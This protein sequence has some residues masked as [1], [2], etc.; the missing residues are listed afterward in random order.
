MVYPPTGSTAYERETSIPPTLLRSM[1]LLY[2]FTFNISSVQWQTG[3]EHTFSR[4]SH[5]FT[6]FLPDAVAQILATPLKGV[7]SAWRGSRT[8]LVGGLGTEV[9][10]RSRGRLSRGLGCLDD[11]MNL[12]NVS[13]TNSFIFMRSLVAASLL[14]FC[15]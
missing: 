7:R 10:Q 1:T 6:V 9:S 12:K 14:A 13:P 11:E 4:S 3:S 5:R 2:L 15:I 8:L